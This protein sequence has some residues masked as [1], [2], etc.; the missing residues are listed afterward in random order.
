M[1]C[2]KRAPNAGLLLHPSD[3]M[4]L[5]FPPFSLFNTVQFCGAKGL[6][7]LMDIVL[8]SARHDLKAA[9]IWENAQGRSVQEGGR[10]VTPAAAT[11]CSHVFL[12]PGKAMQGSGSARILPMSVPESSPQQGPRDSFQ[13]GRPRPRVGRAIW[14]SNATPWI[15][16]MCVCVCMHVGICL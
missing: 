9:V 7:T 16:Q 13:G 5:L 1:G 3:K 8:Y 12:T 4:C 6:E 15:A 2:P 14:E 10:G 11:C